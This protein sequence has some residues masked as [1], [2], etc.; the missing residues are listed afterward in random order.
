MVRRFH[1]HV[2]PSVDQ[3]GPLV[4]DRPPGER[5]RRVDRG[6]TNCR[7]DSYVR[8]ELR[9]L[10]AP[11]PAGQLRVGVL[12]RRRARDLRLRQRT[13]GARHR[14]RLRVHQHH[15]VMVVVHHLDAIGHVDYDPAEHG[16]RAFNSRR[17][18]YILGSYTIRRP[19]LTRTA[20]RP[21]QGHPTDNVR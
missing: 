10:L 17:F 20:G 18:V 16:N 5:V 8:L 14:P 15:V 7:V 3:L 6:Q 9:M 12:L 4:P 21:E 2:M 11:A 13:G 19:I 1:E